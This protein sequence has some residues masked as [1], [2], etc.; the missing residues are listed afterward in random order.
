MAERRIIG[1]DL[2]IA[3]EHTVRVLT[4]DGRMVAK[5][6]AVPTAE[7]LTALEQAALAGA[8][9]GTV[10]E[11]VMEPTGPAWLPVA[12]FFDRR[13][14]RVFRVPSA[15][16]HDMRR[17]FSR[18]AKSN[19]IDAE[20]LARLA[21]VTP[22]V[23]RPL[24]LG[25][26]DAAAL[27][28]RVRACDRLTQAASLHKV[29]IKDLVRQLLPMTPLTGDLGA[30]DLAVLERYGDPRALV[31]LGGAGSPGSSTGPRSAT[32]GRNEPMSGW[33]RP[34]A[35]SSSMAITT[36]WRSVTWR[37]RWPPR[38]GCSGPFRPSWPPTRRSARS[39]I[40]GSIPN[41]WPAASR[42]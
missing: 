22:E 14:H 18:H 40:G 13:G 8:A 12:V 39:A 19:S 25:G 17:V 23:L 32:R 4:G 3:S 24:A 42:G 16:A 7:S 35:L 29:R 31:K 41:C 38:C 34:A 30:A 5:R 2:G 20:A 28:R 11:V 33:P 6:K 9:P 37:P 21:I 26:V 15:V 1:L 10:L 27:D 36:P